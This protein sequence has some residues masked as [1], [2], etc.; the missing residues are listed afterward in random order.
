M[1][2]KVLIIDDD[3]EYVDAINQ[4]VGRQGLQCCQCPQWYGR[5]GCC[6]VEQT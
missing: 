4:S 3:V 1:A 2:K 5:R 6:Q